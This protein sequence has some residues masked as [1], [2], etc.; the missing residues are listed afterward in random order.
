MSDLSGS[1]AR[2]VCLRGTLTGVS[3]SSS[4]G[5]GTLGAEKPKVVAVV[6]SSSVYTGSDAS[7]SLTATSP[8]AKLSVGIGRNF[9]I[10]VYLL[11]CCLYCA[12]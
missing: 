4:E 9:K 10:T 12:H 3:G 1:S 2:S 7:P 11:S 5:K 8:A 6:G